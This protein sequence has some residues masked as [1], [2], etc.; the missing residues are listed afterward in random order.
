MMSNIYK[1]NIT[2]LLDFNI[3][4]NNFDGLYDVLKFISRKKDLFTIDELHDIIFRTF[5]FILSN[6]SFNSR[7]DSFKDKVKLH[8][9]DIQNYYLEILYAEMIL[10]GQ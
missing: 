9:N 10:T 8:I 7:E 5:N 2:K 3:K 4:L 1:I 6:E